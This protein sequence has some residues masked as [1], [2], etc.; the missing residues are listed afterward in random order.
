M[1]YRAPPWQP[2]DSPIAVA[3]AII[4]VALAASNFYRLFVQSGDLC[5][6]LP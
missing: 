2:T 6:V 5:K 1:G 4:S 3:S